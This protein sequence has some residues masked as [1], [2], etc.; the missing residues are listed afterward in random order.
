VS[1]IKKRTAHQIII[2]KYK[3]PIMANIHV[4]QYYSN[5]E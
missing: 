4:W 5:G 2:T 3:G 1:Y